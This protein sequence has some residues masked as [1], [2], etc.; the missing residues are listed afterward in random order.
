MYYKDYFSHVEMFFFLKDWKPDHIQ[1]DCKLSAHDYHRDGLVEI[2]PLEKK[3]LLKFENDIDI[4]GK[5]LIMQKILPWFYV[6]ER[7]LNILDY[8]VDTYNYHYGD[9]KDSEFVDSIKAIEILDN[10]LNLKD[11]YYGD[12]KPYKYN[13]DD[14]GL[15]CIYKNIKSINCELHSSECISELDSNGTISIEHIYNY[16]MDYESDKFAYNVIRDYVYIKYGIK[17]M[18]IDKGYDGTYFV[19]N[20]EKN[21]K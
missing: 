11:D 13:S 1:A 10:W 21:I 9:I 8:E 7:Q 20:K 2:L 16:L 19:F 5:I 12:D 6:G 4:E 18:I 3:I 17:E 14:Y 15:F